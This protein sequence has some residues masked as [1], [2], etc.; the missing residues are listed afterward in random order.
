[1][2]NHKIIGGGGV[3]LNVIE[4][5]N[6]EGRPILFIPG[7]SQSHFAWKHQLNSD[8]ANDHRLIALDL[9]G[10]GASGKPASLDAY[11][12]SKL[13]A[14][15][16]NAVIQ[17]LKLESPILS[18]WSYGPLII[19]DY[20]RYYGEEHIGGINFVGGISD[21]GTEE[22]TALLT[23]NILSLVPGFFSTNVEESVR[24]LGSL[25]RLFLAREPTEAEFYFMLG[26][27]V[28]VP[29]HV[30]QALFSRTLENDDLLT[31]LKTPLL[32]SH[33]VDDKIVHFEAAT[34]IAS[35]VQHAQIHQTANLG[36]AVFW[37]DPEGFNTRL[38]EFAAS[39]DS[40][41]VDVATA[42]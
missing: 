33:S 12:D 10:H 7:F 22:A 16:V 41:N 14:D 2:K 42:T 3:E 32:I 29:P 15:D 9:R 25:I 36:H 5:G 6:P 31:K 21:L 20:I 40:R 39:L 38:R 4:T 19:L 17:T 18:G 23:P 28:S 1:M 13:W 35:L 34:R 26:Y 37:E 11:T 24:D 8:L 30:R 27:N